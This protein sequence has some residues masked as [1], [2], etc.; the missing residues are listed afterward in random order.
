MQNQV[1]AVAFDQERANSYDQRFAAAAPLRESL[2]LLTRAILADLP[3]DARVLC[4]GA[5]TGL[6]L[7]DLA[8]AYPRWRFTA[9]EPSAPMLNV[10][11]QKAAE[12]G[13][14][15]RCTFHEGYL[16]TL[17]AAGPFDA[18]TCFLVSHFILPRDE[19]R[20][21]FRQIAARLR[22]GGT[23]VSADLASDQSSAAY[24]SLL[25]VWLR[26]MRPVDGAA[27]DA[28]KT[29]EAYRRNVAILPPPEVS[30]LLTES[31]F[32]SPVLFLQTLLIHA[33]YATR[34]A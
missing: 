13:V 25:E 26:V 12:A 2:H 24:E 22:P 14:A 28:Q 5:G 17:P 34:T 3:A 30:A 11:R 15:D 29:R 18:A 8:R 6:E 9:V 1:P 16:D 20:D 4:V 23:L 21:F 27:G 32:A 7:L 31:G 19:R 33:W 10:C